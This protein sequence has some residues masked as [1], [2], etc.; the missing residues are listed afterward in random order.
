[1]NPF[2]SEA[3]PAIVQ[4]VYKID[5]IQKRLIPFLK[6]KHFDDY[7]FWNDRESADYAKPVTQLLDSK[8][9]KE[10]DPRVFT[11]IVES[12]VTRLRKLVQ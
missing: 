7:M 4:N 12:N 10:V 9:V 6:N 5:R 2:F 11:T 3:L 1:M 8:N